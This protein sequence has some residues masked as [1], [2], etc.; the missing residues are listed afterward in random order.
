MPDQITTAAELEDLLC[1]LNED[2]HEPY[3]LVV[4]SRPKPALVWLREAASE[5]VQ[6]GVTIGEP[7][8]KHFT[9]GLSR[10]QTLDWLKYP[11]T[12]LYRPDAPSLGADDHAGG[13]LKGAPNPYAAIESGATH[14]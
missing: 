14:G 1:G 5:E 2:G 4:D 8:L 10:N 13:P 6:A 12:V 11:V 9:D 7:G 3:L